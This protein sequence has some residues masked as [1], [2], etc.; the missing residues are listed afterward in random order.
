MKNVKFKSAVA[1]V[2]EACWEIFQEL[3]AQGKPLPEGVMVT[4]N[5][6]GYYNG[7]VHSLKDVP[8]SNRD[9]YSATCPDTGRKMVLVPLESFYGFRNEIGKNV[10]HDKEDCLVFF[11]R[12][13]GGGS[14]VLIEQLTQYN[15]VDIM[16]T[17]KI[18]SLLF[19]IGDWLT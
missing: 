1:S 9:I 17:M 18:A 13:S 16:P 4:G 12:Y 5:G 6:T 8:V 7:M 10:R 15:N 11:E 14:Q 3:H 2:S 19:V